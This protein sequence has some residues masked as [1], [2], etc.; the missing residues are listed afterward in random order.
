VREELV[1]ASSWPSASRQKPLARNHYGELN[2]GFCNIVRGVE[3]QRQ[4]SDAAIARTTPCLLALFSIVTLLAAR[5]ARGGKLPVRS[6]A[7]YHKEQ[8]TFSDT[9]AAVRQHIWRWGFARSCRKRDLAKLPPRLLRSLQEAS[10]Y[11]A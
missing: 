5:L 4:W 3:T 1:A 6:E 2:R 10:C 7:W 8:A 9:L 11:A